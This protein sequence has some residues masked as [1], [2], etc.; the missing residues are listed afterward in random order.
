MTPT[1]YTVYMDFYTYN[2]IA[3]ETPGPMSFAIDNQASHLC[4]TKQSCT[5]HIFLLSICSAINIPHCSSH[6]RS[7]LT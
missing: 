1:S 5:V 4:A 3:N 6:I 2:D 7:L